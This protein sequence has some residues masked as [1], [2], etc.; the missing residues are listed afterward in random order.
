MRLSIASTAALFLAGAAS[1]A[2]SWAFSDATV[3]I[4]SK[5][6]GDAQKHAF[7][8]KDGVGSV[9]SWRKDDSIKVELTAKEGSK[10]Q[11]PHQAFVVLKD[12]GSGLEA[13]FPFAV[14]ESGKGVA[15][16]VRLDDYKIQ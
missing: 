11:R 7:T 5:A 15:E 13:S 16:I 3:Q 2:S 6:A 12:A 1:A 10:K 4:V 8:D 14:K 9:L